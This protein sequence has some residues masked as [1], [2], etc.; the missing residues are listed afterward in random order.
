MGGCDLFDVFTEQEMLSTRFAP[1]MPV[2]E[3]L[4][5]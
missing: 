3:S 1:S 5:I 4:N 2:A